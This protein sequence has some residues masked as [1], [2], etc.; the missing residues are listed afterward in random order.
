MKKIWIKLVVGLVIIAAAAVILRTKKES[1]QAVVQAP[2]NQ[3]TSTPITL[4]DGRLQIDTPT[5]GNPVGQTFT[6]SGYAQNWFEGNI[7]VKVFD[8]NG[9]KLY[10]G[11]AIAG[12]NYE[13]PAPFNSFI[14][15]TA[16]PATPTGKIEFDD[17]S[18]KDGSLVYQKSVMINF[19]ITK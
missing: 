2:L 10:Q 14:T 18:A 4:A 8:A 12:D 13:H 19:K 3:A 11:N 5:T 16:T 15:L 7:S 6:V 9:N 17:Y 1:K